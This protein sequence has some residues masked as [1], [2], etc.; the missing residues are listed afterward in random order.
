MSTDFLTFELLTSI[1]NNDEII[2]APQKDI[3]Q[4]LKLSIS[5][6]PI[7]ITIPVETTNTN[8]KKNKTIFKREIVDARL[9]KTSV[10]DSVL[11]NDEPI[12]HNDRKKYQTNNSII[13]GRLINIITII[14]KTPNVLFII[15]KLL[16]T[17]DTASL[18]VPPTTGIN[19]PDINLIP[20][21]TN[22]S[23]EDAKRLWVVK[24]PVKTVE[25]NDKTRIISFLSVLLIFK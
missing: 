20:F 17:D 12:E 21:K 18:T 3:I 4:S 5:Y 15:I 25:N 6:L 9:S 10:T 8:V 11:N 1:L 2:P 23:E 14:T 19:A 24:R 16:T 7:I 22:P 13:T